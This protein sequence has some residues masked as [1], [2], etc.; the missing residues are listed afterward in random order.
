MEEPLDLSVSWLGLNSYLN[1]LFLGPVEYERQYLHRTGCGVCEFREKC[2]SRAFCWKMIKDLKMMK[3][4]H[5][6]THQIL[7]SVGV[8]R[9]CLG[10]TPWNRSCLQILLNVR[11]KV[12]LIIGIWVK[13]VFRE[14]LDTKFPIL[15]C[16]VEQLSLS[17]AEVSSWTFKIMAL[18]ILLIC[19]MKWIGKFI[20]QNSRFLISK[21]VVWSKLPRYQKPKLN[22]YKAIPNKTKKF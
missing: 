19:C 7:L 20:S 10:C 9:L 13:R 12:K 4:K 5:W 3:M 14:K 21:I 15:L 8:L 11:V 1:T 17:Q 18:D 6:T 2:K 22:I 16:T